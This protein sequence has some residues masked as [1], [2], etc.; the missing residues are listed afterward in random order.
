MDKRIQKALILIEK[1]YKDKILLQDLADAVGLS[2]FHF[3][4]LFKKETGESPAACVARIRLDKAA[5]LI[6]VNEDLPMTRIA[7]DCGFSSPASFSRAFTQKFGTSPSQFRKQGLEYQKKEV[8]KGIFPAEVVY[9][10]KTTIFYS[11]TSIYNPNM[12]QVFESTEALC[13][14]EGALAKERTR[15]GIL[16]QM[17]F[18]APKEQL[19][20]YAGIQI[21]TMP[22]SLPGDRIYTI[23][24]GRYVR[25]Y[26][27]TSYEDL[28]SLL[29]QF[30][31]GWLNKMPY[32]I[33]EL[34]AFEHILNENKQSDYPKIKRYIYLPVKKQ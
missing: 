12:L 20:Y 26:T 30:Q 1:K 8:F 17:P 11:Q 27:D 22:D 13:D 14:M 6:R 21:S 33:T 25:F 4:K 19:N 3:Q 34:F 18:H 16:A 29:V 28:L 10:P 24:A 32:F 15:F 23:P 5:H 7:M 9:F 31:N 2:A